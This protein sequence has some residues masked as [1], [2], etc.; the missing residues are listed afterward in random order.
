MA[1]IDID[2]K[3]YELDDQQNLLHGCLSNG[4]DV[5]YFCWH[6][7]LGSVGACRLC[8][9]KQ[10]NDANDTKGRIVM[11]CMTPAK[12]VARIS[13]KDPEV[14]DFR[15]RIVEFLMT[16]HPHDCPVCD[17]GGACHLQDMTVLVGHNYR[18]HRFAKRTHV[19]QNLGPLV[20]HEMNR[21][22]QCYRCVRYYQN[23]AGGTDLGVFAS[24]ANV[25]FGRAESG[26]L[27]SEFAGNLVE[28]CPTG[29]FTDKTMKQHYT[30]KWD[31]QMAPSVCTHCSAGCNITPGERYGTLR[32]VG[33]RYNAEV[34]SYFLCDRGRFGYEFV[35]RVDRIRAATL[36]EGKEHLPAET[37]KVTAHIAAAIRRG[38]V[39]GIGS[40][41]ASLESNFAL[42][43]LVGGDA[44]F[45]GIGAEE[46]ALTTRVMQILRDGPR[47]PT[48]QEI[49]RSD[50]ALVLGEDPSNTAPRVA[51]ALRQAGHRKV[52]DEAGA[53]LGVPEW[54]DSPLNTATIG[55]AGQLFIAFPG[56]TRLDASASLAWRAN[57]DEI[58]RLGFAI[59]H[60]LDPEAP[61][62]AGL[63]D[64]DA[65]LAAG[66][67][68]QLA[69]SKRPVVVS[70]IHLGH[71]GILE[72]AANIAMAL[73]KLGKNPGLSYLLPEANSFGLATLGAASL[74]QAIAKVEAGE[75]DTILVLENDL[76]RRLPK[77]K[78]NRLFERAR[79]LAI[80][81]LPHRTVAW[82]EAVLPTAPFAEDTG[83]YVNFEGRAQRFFEV[84]V[85][86]APIRSSWQWL[87][88]IGAQAGRSIPDH[89]D[90]LVDAM[91]IA[92]PAL[93]PVAHAAPYS[94]FRVQG[95]KLSRQPARYSGRTAMNANIN[96][97]EQKPATDL[98]SP[99]AFSMEGFTSKA[100]AT[101]VPFFWAPNWNSNQA[102][103]KFQSKIG[104]PLRGE[105][106]GARLVE[107]SAQL[108]YSSPPGKVAKR[109]LTPVPLYQVFGSEEQSRRAEGIS[110]LIHPLA[111]RVNPSLASI[112]GSQWTWNEQDYHV[113][114]D[115]SMAEGVV[116]IEV[117]G[118][119]E[120]L[121]LPSEISVTREIQQ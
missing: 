99:Y 93:A 121:A 118:A 43:Q 10:Y 76:Y 48:L 11:S 21:C 91:G 97:S 58:A 50:C 14:L 94:G 96:V 110:K 111:V 7:A 25:Y 42:R 24:K 52:R 77:E 8:A 70:G 33:N 63:S 83:T 12:G 13:V 80:D 86:A 15:K 31:L 55:Q 46:H 89:F 73:Q 39:I 84:Y 38:K 107:G 98:E 105:P 106:I 69:A 82:A 88:D 114:S 37:S 3:E 113:I 95:L 56:G 68:H 64:E 1:K 17:A 47:T 18:R 100:A 115:Q 26:T 65:A 79:I 60:A 34:N 101:V 4:L 16:S 35:N 51:L 5:P 116:G 109:A 28:V 29:V 9:V 62:V 74:N 120:A 102:V 119:A 108:P 112:F 59:A 57:P 75:A 6:P 81:H 54:N 66:L 23:Y 117:D 71:A 78:I 85:P 19:N 20:N 87:A 45:A 49:E 44:F 30:R 90:A 40:P 53:A 92:F 61:P 41:R 36:R 2:G 32:G 104:G 27:E 103:N 72:A 67:A 22:I